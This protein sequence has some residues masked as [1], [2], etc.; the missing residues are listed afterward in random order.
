M[1]SPAPPSISSGHRPARLRWTAPPGVGGNN[2]QQ[3]VAAQGIA[4][5][6]APAVSAWVPGGGFLH[7]FC[8]GSNR[9]TMCDQIS[10]VGAVLGPVLEGMNA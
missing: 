4:G 10:P 3:A 9:D 2:S 7:S 5:S 1:K 8:T 6:V